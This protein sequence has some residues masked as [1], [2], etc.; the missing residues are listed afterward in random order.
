MVTS[1]PSLVM[2]GTLYPV[3]LDGKVIVD[4]FVRSFPMLVSFTIHHSEHVAVVLL[5]AC[6]I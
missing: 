3:W 2:C 5:I 1:A 6:I 4:I